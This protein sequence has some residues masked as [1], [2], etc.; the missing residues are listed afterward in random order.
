M[1]DSPEDGDGM[2]L[3]NTG[4]Y[5]LSPHGITTQKTNANSL[6]SVCFPK[7]YNELRISEYKYHK[8]MDITSNGTK[9]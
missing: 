4:I 6:D 2:F 7:R 8:K 5:L 1:L 9:K 3:Q